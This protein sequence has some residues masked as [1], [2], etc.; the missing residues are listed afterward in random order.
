[1]ADITKKIEELK[2][3]AE[4]ETQLKEKMAYLEGLLNDLRKS[5]DELRKK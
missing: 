1:M 3:L 2:P 4:K 5:V